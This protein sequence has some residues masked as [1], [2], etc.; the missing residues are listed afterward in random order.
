M[1][2][3]DIEPTNDF[4]AKA[5]TK[6][7]GKVEKVT[8]TLPNAGLLITGDK[9]L[10]SGSSASVAKTASL[11]KRRQVELLTPSSTS[12]TVKPNKKGKRVLAEDG[13]TKVKLRLT[14]TPTFG[15]ALTKTI[16]VKL[17]D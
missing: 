6:N 14:Y 16:K 13:R 8:A 11:L 17:K 7:G 3:A 12:L 4:T 10:A 9:K 2:N 1:I 15:V 5:K